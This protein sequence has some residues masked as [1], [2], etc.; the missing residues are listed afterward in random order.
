VER[1][2]KLL[3]AGISVPEAVKFDN[4]YLELAGKEPYL[5]S[6]VH[7]T[8][9]YNIQAAERKKS[10][11]R[12]NI[13][14]RVITEIQDK[15]FISEIEVGLGK[16]IDR[17][18]FVFAETAKY[19]KDCVVVAGYDHSF[20]VSGPF[21]LT[22]HV[23]VT[24]DEEGK[25]IPLCGGFTCTRTTEDCSWFLERCK[26]YIG[27]VDVI[28]SDQDKA[29]AAAVSAVYLSAEH[30]LCIWHFYRTLYEHFSSIKTSDRKRFEHDV[31]AV[32]NIWDTGVFEERWKAL[33]EEWDFYLY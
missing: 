19:R 10:G 3:R 1:L 11:G 26:K 14:G 4:T 2:T 16:V 6:D 28:C 33:K 31:R 12:N 22:L 8:K 17:H 24:L 30:I 29:I 20:G 13:W 32:S 9:L 15:G 18:F 5:L 27:D 25:V 23:F 7:L 21:E